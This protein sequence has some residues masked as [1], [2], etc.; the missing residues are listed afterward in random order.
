M[1]NEY[2]GRLHVATGVWRLVSSPRAMIPPLPFIFKVPVVE[3]LVG[4]PSM[5]AAARS[6]VPQT[7]YHLLM[8]AAI[9]L[10]LLADQPL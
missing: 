3:D 1:Q 7:F 9:V 5:A 10:A 4:A 2:T 6:A 8:P